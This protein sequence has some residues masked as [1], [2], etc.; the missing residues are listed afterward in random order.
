MNT[1][2]T[3]NVE[4]TVPKMTRS[5]SGLC[6]RMSCRRVAQPLVV[7]CHR[8]KTP[9][10]QLSMK[11]EYFERYRI[12]MMNHLVA[13]RHSYTGCAT[14]DCGGSVRRSGVRRNRATSVR[15]HDFEAD[16]CGPER[17]AATRRRT[18]RSGEAGRLASAPPAPL[19]TLSLP[20]NRTRP[21]S[22]INSNFRTKRSGSR[23]ETR[24]RREIELPCPASRLLARTWSRSQRIR[25][26]SKQREQRQGLIPASALSF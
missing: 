17:H 21:T 22:T 25:N 16:A 15:R 3:L 7:G 13:A 2:A 9:H 26:R 12:R 19:R 5:G 14:R 6:C 1:G 24:R 20:K 4:K 10:P 8:H 23:K 11:I 18:H